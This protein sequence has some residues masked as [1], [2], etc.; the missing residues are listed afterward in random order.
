MPVALLPRRRHLRPRDRRCRSLQSDALADGISG[1]CTPNHD[2][3]IS[4]AE[5]P[6]IAGRSASFRIA[7]NATWS[8]AGTS[9]QDGS[10]TWDPSGQLSGDA[11][12]PIA[13][14]APAG[15]WWQTDFPSA[16]Y[17]AP[18]SS[19][20][21]LLGVFEVGAAS[22]TLLGVVSPDGGSTRTQLAYTPS[23]KILALP[24][25][26]GA[27]WTSTSTVTGVA[28]SVIV[29]YSEEYQSSVDQVGTMITPYGSFPVLRVATD[30]TRT[31]GL[32]TL[33]TNRTFAWVAEC[34]GSVA[35]VQSQSYESGTEFSDDAEVERLVP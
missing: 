8:T 15:A 5:L 21:T 26:A 20:S 4:L 13:L 16:T 2:G 6:L 7:T 32:A 30:L 10:R 22:V 17:A 14:A 34:F 11:D 31:E 9:S 28:E 1:A 25:G 35:T 33:L 29:D 12:S 18:L 23:A 24:F 3:Q 27:T 19:S